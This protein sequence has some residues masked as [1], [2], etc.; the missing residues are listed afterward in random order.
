MNL[1]NKI[2]DIIKTIL[3][4]SNGWLVGSS[5]KNIMEN[6]TPK[7]YDII[8]NAKAFSSCLAFFRHHGVSINHYGGIDFNIK[9]LKIQIWISSLEK[10]LIMAK[11]WTYAYNAKNKIL[12]QRSE[13]ECR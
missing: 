4:T 10:Y 11:K 2:P 8:V 5:V 9:D 6:K 13:N 3:I 7:D 12:I 1:N